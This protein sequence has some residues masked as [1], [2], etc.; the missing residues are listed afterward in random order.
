MM[1][2]QML[3][4]MQQTMVNMQN[5]QPQAP[6]PPPRDRLGD[7]Q[8]IKPPTFS[9]SMEPMDANDWIKIVERKLQG[10]QCNNREKVLL[11]LHQ[12]IGPAADWWDAYVEAHEEPD[13]INWNEFKMAF[14]SH[15]V[16]HSIIKL[17]KK[18]FQDLKQGSMTVSKYLTHFTQL[19]HYAPNDVGTDEKKQE[20]FLNGL[21]DGLAYGLEARDFENFT[22]MVDKALVLENRRGILSSKCKQEFQS[23]LSSNSKPRINV[24]S[25]PARPI[26]RPVTQSFQLMPQPTAEGFVTPKRQIISHP[27]PLSD[28]KHW[29]SECS[30][31]PD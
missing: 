7:F 10:V 20:C 28:S 14:Y 6:P 27:Q 18:E 21:D 22:A 9:H 19:S 4:T 13:I 23:Q 31:D 25:S 29:E 24:N 12:L 26:I 11:S 8:R 3:Q 1:Q 17:K 5:A 2:A 16:P 30:K 15:H